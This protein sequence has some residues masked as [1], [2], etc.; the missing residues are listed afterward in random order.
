MLYTF[1]SILRS[2]M[3]GLVPAIHDLFAA[4]KRKTWMPATSAGMTSVL[5]V[6]ASIF[7]VTETFAQQRPNRLEIW[8][9]E[10]WR[11][12]LAEVEGSAELVAER[13][14]NA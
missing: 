13:L 12:Q 1:A 6:I 11:R 10:T 2:V 4:A 5:I 14:A 7:G 3:A 9:R 8:D